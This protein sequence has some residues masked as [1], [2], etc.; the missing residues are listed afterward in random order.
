[1]Y[2]HVFEASNGQ[3]D[4]DVEA[5]M[6]EPEWANWIA[7]TLADGLQAPFMLD[8]TSV[9][10]MPL[11]QKYKLD[12]SLMIV[13]PIKPDVFWVLALQADAAQTYTEQQKRLFVDIA[14]RVRG[15]LGQL[16]LQKDLQATVERVEVASRA[17]SEFLATMSHELRTPLHGVIGLLDLLSED[18]Q[19][20]PKEQQRN[21]AL[22][23]T[24][25]QVLSSLI[26]DVLDLAKIES[27]KVEIQKQAFHLRDALHDAL[28]PFV[29]KAREKGL[30]LSLEMKDVPAVVEG[31]VVRLRQV[32]LN[33]V[34]NAIKFTMQGYVRIVVIQDDDVLQINIEDSGIGI[35]SDKQKVVFQPFTQVHDIEILG[36]N[37]QEKGTGLGTTISQYFVEMMGGTLELQSVPGV[38]STMMIRLPLQQVGQQR[39]NLVLHMDDFSQL[40]AEGD[41]HGL[42]GEDIQAWSVLLAE[43]D[44]VGRRIA[45]KRLQ[46]AGFTVEEVADGQSAWEKVQQQDYDLLLTDIRMPGMSGLELTQKIRAHE[47]ERHK[48]PMLVIGLSAYALE[49][50]RQEAMEAG[51]DA[52]VSKPVDMRALMDKLESLCD[53]RLPNQYRQD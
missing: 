12:T 36:D 37:L 49:E 3:H 31:D 35:D 6:C 17:K 42:A 7:Q 44:P 19:Q 1:M 21:L 23:R 39:L 32:L 15:A 43:D 41:A 46:R 45:I 30:S 10:S 5:L 40:A 33:L 48:K 22:A 16:I 4:V 34:G 14:H 53:R 25:S 11:I 27:G 52:F 13:L 18:M 29:M 50:I 28:V 47:A 38:G 9:F 24:S 26:D 2:Q 20:L 51:M 8:V